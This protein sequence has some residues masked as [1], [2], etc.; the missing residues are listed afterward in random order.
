MTEQS[1]RQ[2]FF[3]RFLFIMMLTLTAIIVAGWYL[4]NYDFDALIDPEQILAA[5]EKVEQPVQKEKPPAIKPDDQVVIE[6]EKNLFLAGDWDFYPGDFT[7]QQIIGNSL[8]A[9]WRPYQATSPWN[10]KISLNAYT[11]PDSEAIMVVMEQE[12]KNIRL[13]KRYNPPVWVVNSDNMPKQKIK[14]DKIFDTWDKDRDNWTDVDVPIVESM[15]QEPTRDG[16]IIIVDPFKMKAWE[17]SKFK[18]EQTPEGAIPTSTTFNVWDLKGTG[19]ALPLDGQRWHMR[20]GR[21]S[22]FPVLAGLIRPEELAAGEIRHA[23]L[24]VF[25]KNRKGRGDKEIFISPPAVRSDGQFEGEQFPIQGMRFQLNPELTESDFDEWG[26][27]REGKIVARAL[28]HYG[29]FLGDD[30]GAMSIGIQLLAPSKEEHLLEWEKRA[31]GL[32]RSVSKIPTNE[33]HVVFT[34]FPQEE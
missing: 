15:W 29:M 19:Y 17:M 21:G 8:P 23:L 34:D 22:G 11:H 14:S 32:Y 13:I 9:S 5:Q 31:P 1:G 27:S 4:L 33:F 25:S 6:K 18:W 20:G 12:A 28:Q 26:L 2:R 30:G 3:I 24:L 7:Q 16:H 10:T